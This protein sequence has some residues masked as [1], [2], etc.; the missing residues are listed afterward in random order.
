MK[1]HL[2]HVHKTDVRD[3]RFKIVHQKNIFDGALDYLYQETER[4]RAL[5]RIG[6]KKFIVSFERTEKN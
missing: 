4:N 5:K 1:S 3:E 2:T 6:N